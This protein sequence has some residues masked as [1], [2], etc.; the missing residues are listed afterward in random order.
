MA[1]W[2]LRVR[3]IEVRSAKGKTVP[4][5]EPAIEVD[6][7][8]VEERFGAPLGPLTRGLVALAAAADP[9]RPNEAL[10]RLGTK[11]NLSFDFLFHAPS[12]IEED[13]PDGLLPFAT[14]HKAYYA[15]DMRQSPATTDDAPIMF[16]DWEEGARPRRIAGSMREWL[17]AMARGGTDDD[18]DVSRMRYN[19]TLLLEEGSG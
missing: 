4:A 11:K 2:L 13:A 10:L 9:G 6:V 7:A 8:E 3:R 14:D 19:V 17:S 16:A 1:D 15:L 5:D 12:D 18:A